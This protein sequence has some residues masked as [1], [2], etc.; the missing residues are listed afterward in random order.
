MKEKLIK[1]SPYILVGV[2]VLYLGI[3]YDRINRGLSTEDPEETE[4]AAGPV[5]VNLLNQKFSFEEPC[6]INFV[7][8]KDKKFEGNQS[9]HVKKDDLYAL[10]FQYDSMN[11]MKKTKRVEIN[12]QLMSNTPVKSSIIV[13][14]FSNEK[15]NIIYKSAGMSDNFRIN[16]WGNVFAKFEVDRELLK[17]EKNFVFKSYIM[18]EKGEEMFI[19]NLE[20]NFFGE[21]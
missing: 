5:E 15:G 6:A 16:E 20:I 19:D 4:Q 7:A 13:V 10:T 1:W 12:F 17:N 14:S 2:I 9:A 18:N 3:K 8:E 21:N 11:V